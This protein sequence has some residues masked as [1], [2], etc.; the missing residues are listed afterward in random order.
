MD[1]V[2]ISRVPLATL[3]S[4]IAVIPQDA[5]LFSGTL[6]GNLDP[7]RT[8]SDADLMEVV[9]QTGMAASVKATALGTA[10]DAAGA[11]GAST[12][13]A[14]EAPISFSD[15]NLLNVRVLEGGANFSV[16]ERQLLSIARGMLRKAKIV[17]LDEAT[18][19]V[20]GETDGLIQKVIRT[21]FAGATRLTIAHRIDTIVDSDFILVLDQG[22]VAEF[23]PPAE[24]LA[25][26]SIFAS[27]VAAQNKQGAMPSA[28]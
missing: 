12:A 25:Q 7:G 3:R 22:T 24:L 17:V 20:D 1:G 26:D 23:A 14:A 13:H 6:R 21:C 9:K 16:G 4:R 8:A 27:L 2:D 5:L 28:T 18:S 11:G 19:N 15:A 10:I